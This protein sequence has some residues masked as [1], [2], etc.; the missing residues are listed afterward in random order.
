[1]KSLARR[2]NFTK[3]SARAVKVYKAKVASLTS[4]MAD[5]RARMHLLAED[6]VKYESNLKHTTTAKARAEDKEKNARGELRIV[7]DE[8]R[9][10]RDELQVSRDELHV[11]RDELR[12]KAT[13]LSR[14]SQEAFEAVIS[15]EHLTKECHRLRGGLQRQEAL[16]SQKKGVIAKLR[17]E[18]CTLWASGWLAFR[19]KAA[20]AFSGLDLTFQ[21]PDEREA[22]ESDSD[23][24]AYLVVFSD[25]LR[26]VPLRVDL[27]IEAHAAAD[28]PTSV[29]GTSPFELHGL[30]VR[31]TKAAQSPTLDF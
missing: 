22:E 21:V 9:A 10:I 17:D 1:M 12:I 24:E 19:R 28:S 4:E 30:E 27:E 6:A 20:K 31:V 16:V 7:E 14:A 11:V 8:L 5:L 18:A 3:G 29:V 2:A 15:V 13:T 26:F 23:D 25:A